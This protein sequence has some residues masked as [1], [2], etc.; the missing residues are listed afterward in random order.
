M[1][2]FIGQIDML[3]YTFAPRNY[4]FC[5][6]QVV[7][8]YQNQAL[9]AIIGTTYGGNGVTNMGIPDLQGRTPTMFGTGPGLS[10]GDMGYKVGT[11][12]VTLLESQLPSHSHEMYSGETIKNGLVDKSNNTG[13][14]SA[15]R[16]NA[17]G[18]ARVYSSE[19]RTGSGV[20]LNYN[21]VL[22]NGQNLAHE[23]R[24]PYLAV[25]FCLCIDGIFPPRS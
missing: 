2:P 11:P 7:D 19:L 5:D 1:D 22:S 12:E 6:G 8:I 20:P 4:T 14:L 18:V 3:P 10:P 21:S 23:N 16:A 9:Y 25:Q 24:Q 13:L 17:G 15:A